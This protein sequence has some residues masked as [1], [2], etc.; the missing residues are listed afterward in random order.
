MVK[1][2]TRSAFLS[3]L[4]LSRTF[5][6]RYPADKD[7]LSHLHAS[8][9]STKNIRHK[10]LISTRVNNNSVVI[11]KHSNIQHAY[12]TK[13]MYFQVKDWRHLNKK[14]RRWSLESSTS[15]LHAQMEL[16]IDFLCFNYLHNL[17]LDKT[18]EAYLSQ[19]TLLA[20]ANKK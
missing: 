5:P 17:Q 9:S 18:S 6:A 19:P 12:E 16:R 15:S 14:E 20:Y 10:I 4:Y 3:S 11:F 8:I 1:K 7:L 13:Y 2:I